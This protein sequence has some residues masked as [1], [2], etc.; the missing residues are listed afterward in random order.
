MATVQAEK[1]A[2]RKLSLLQVAQE[3]GNVSKACRIVGYSRQQFYEIGWTFQLHGADGLIDRLP[4]ARGPDKRLLGA[5]ETLETISEGVSPRGLPS[6]LVDEL[7]T[8]PDAVQMREVFVGR[9]ESRSADVSRGGDP[10]VV[11]RHRNRWVRRG[12][13]LWSGY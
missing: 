6:L 4:G 3:L 8:Q 5:S 1:I 9:Q 7:I 2:R 12:G 10:Q 13:S 11:L